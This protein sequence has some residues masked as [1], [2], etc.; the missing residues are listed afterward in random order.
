MNDHAFH[1]LYDSCPRN[2]NP[3]FNFVLRE[4]HSVV[5]RSNLNLNIS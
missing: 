3:F 2:L 1:I 5:R 4:K